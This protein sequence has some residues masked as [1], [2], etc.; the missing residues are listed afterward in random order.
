MGKGRAAKR[1]FA[2][3]AAAAAI[4]AF[5]TGPA[6]ASETTVCGPT[7][8]PI[9]DMAARQVAH[10][11]NEAEAATDY[12]VFM[13]DKVIAEVNNAYYTVRCTVLEECS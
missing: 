11:R 5:G 7:I 13:G 4:A 10:V 2:V 1:V 8:E 6:A 12:V 3:G 9:C